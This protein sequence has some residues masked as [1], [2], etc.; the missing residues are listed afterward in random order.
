MKKSFLGS[1][2][3]HGAIILAA[4]FGLPQAKVPEII[5]PE[6]IQVDISNITDNTKVKA[7]TKSEEKPKEKPKPKASEAIEKVKPKEKVSEEKKVAMKEP[8]KAEPPP[9]K[10]EE[11]PEPKPKKEPPPKKV[12]DLPL[13]SDP[14]KDMLAAEDKKLEEDKKTEEKKADE[15]KKAEEKKKVDEK[16]AAD[17][18]KKL[19][20]EKKKRKLDV[21]ELEALLN[22]DDTI[23]SSAPVEKKDD[24]GTPEK[25]TKDVQGND[26]AISAT[27]VDALRQKFSEC[28]S[29]PPSV[30]EAGVSV[31][32][33]FD[34]DKQG[35]V[36]GQP[37]VTGGDSDSPLFQT[38]GLAARSAVMTC[39]PFDW[40]PPDRFDLWKNIEWTFK[41]R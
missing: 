21:A 11:K 10:P 30:R 32:V 24:A 9:P 41:P 26:D 39:Q 1:A 14:L 3:F 12:E 38:A 35:R 29:I 23:E 6:A 22:K 37:I 7:Q 18:K 25:A 8:E 5:P 36:V 28:W 19:D 13:D 4:V 34:L 33:S 15:K 27:I 20:G 31:D 2:T 16:A 17:A 40:L